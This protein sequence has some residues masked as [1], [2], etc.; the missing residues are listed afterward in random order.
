MNIRK[1]RPSAGDWR[2]KF[3]ARIYEIIKA[4]KPLPKLSELAEWLDAEVGFQPDLAEVS[5]ELNRR[6]RRVAD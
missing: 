5:R 4:G 3:G 1:A 6:L 2:N